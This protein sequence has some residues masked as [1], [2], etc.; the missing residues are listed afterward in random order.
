MGQNEH[1]A[2]I[3]V[4]YCVQG[5]HG[6]FTWLAVECLGVACQVSVGIGPCASPHPRTHTILMHECRVALQRSAQFAQYRTSASR[7]TEAR[8]TYTVIFRTMSL[9]VLKCSSQRWARACFSAHRADKPAHHIAHPVRFSFLPVYAQQCTKSGYR[10]LQ[11]AHEWGLRGSVYV[12]ML[13]VP[14]YC[15]CCAP[16]FISLSILFR[17]SS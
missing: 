2:L 3:Y 7:N 4:V 17:C 13:S 16:A 8:C 1:T 15:R 5:H 12:Y 6:F 11:I 14:V 10:H 9:P